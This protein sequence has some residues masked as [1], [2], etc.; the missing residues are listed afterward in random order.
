MDSFLNVCFVSDTFNDNAQRDLNC[1]KLFPRN[2][3]TEK[4][5]HL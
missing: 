4:R 5:S 3:Q 2:F 1:S